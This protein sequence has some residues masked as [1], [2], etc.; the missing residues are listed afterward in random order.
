MPGPAAAKDHP[1]QIIDDP[2][3]P[4][5]EEFDL[6]LDVEDPTEVHPRH[7]HA[8]ISAWFDSG[9]RH[10]SSHKA[11]AIGPLWQRPDGRSGLSLR[12]LGD[13]DF[14][15]PGESVRLG[16]VPA[17]FDLAA[18]SLVNTITRRTLEE[19]PPARSVLVRFES[20]MT[21]RQKDTYHPSPNE[22]S[23]LGSWERAAELIGLAGQVDW[24]SVDARII[25]LNGHTATWSTPKARGRTRTPV[26]F[27]GEVGIAAPDGYGQRLHQLAVL[28]GFAG[29][30]SHT[31]FGMGFTTLMA[32]DEAARR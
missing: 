1:L 5:G 24:R 18:S 7:L 3:C 17:R 32:V 12:V 2:D 14:E 16:R 20:P 21:R 10:R 19:L 13:P 30:G 11:Y 29:T 9:E 25:H 23:I 4:L 26:G 27:V 8:V 28:A 6:V 31:T 15:P 22:R